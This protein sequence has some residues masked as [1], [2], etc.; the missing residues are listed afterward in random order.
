MILKPP[1]DRDSFLSFGYVS[2]RSSPQLDPLRKSPTM[3]QAVQTASAH[4]PAPA[5]VGRRSPVSST[6]PLPSTSQKAIEN[7]EH[8]RGRTLAIYY[9]LI[10]WSTSSIQLTFIKNIY[11]M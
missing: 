1:E 2:G 3:E 7:Q 9:F 8:R 5:P 11:S 10:D 4:L 6:R